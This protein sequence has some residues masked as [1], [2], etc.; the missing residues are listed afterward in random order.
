MDLEQ[1][2]QKFLDLVGGINASQLPE[3]FGWI[4][5]SFAFGKCES[6]A[7]HQLDSRVVICCVVEAGWQDLFSVW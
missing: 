1:A 5:E 6:C 4:K 2:K 7:G 3:F